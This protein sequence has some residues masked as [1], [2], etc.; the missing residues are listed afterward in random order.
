MEA[1][2][3]EYRSR[4][5]KHAHDDGHLARSYKASVS[6]ISRFHCGKK[7][8]NSSE[9]NWVQHPVTQITMKRLSQR[10]R[11]RRETRVG[12]FT[13]GRRLKLKRTKLALTIRKR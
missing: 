10:L 2:K 9:Q 12:F 4:S 13:L 11:V 1:A 3:E 7:P 5:S 8:S 6:L